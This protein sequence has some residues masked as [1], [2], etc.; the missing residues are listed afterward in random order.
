MMGMTVNIGGTGALRVVLDMPSTVLTIP[1]V[2]VQQ[3][4]STTINFTAEGSV[5]GSTN[6][7]FDLTEENDLTV[8]YYS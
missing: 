4:V 8:R 7:V 6:S 2:D 1:T 3:V 5:P